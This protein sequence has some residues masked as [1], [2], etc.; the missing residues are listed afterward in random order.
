MVLYIKTLSKCMR[1]VEYGT[2][3]DNV[4]SCRRH[5]FVINADHKEGAHCFVCACDCRVRLEPF[6]IWLWEPL[7][8]THLIRPFLMAM[9]KLL[10][11]TRHRALGFQTDGWSCGFQ[12]LNIV[13]LAVEHR[14]SFF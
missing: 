4:A 10:L 6:I 14:G 2:T 1:I 7:S 12:S 13:K 8:S 5:I 11:T 9:K 3:L